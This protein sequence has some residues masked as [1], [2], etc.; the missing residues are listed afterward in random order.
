MARRWD[1]SWRSWCLRMRK[2]KK[3]GKGKCWRV[4]LRA[5]QVGGGTMK[6][7]RGEEPEARRAASE[8]VYSVRLA[9]LVP[10]LVLALSS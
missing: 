1:W 7:K 5:R 10:V 4:A 9:S 3:I 8:Q 6:V 2:K